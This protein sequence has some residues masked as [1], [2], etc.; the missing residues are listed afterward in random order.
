MITFVPPNCCA[1]TRK[2]F[3]KSLV[4]LSDPCPTNPLHSEFP[5]P[6]NL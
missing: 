3:S 4:Q 5:Y 6:L 1:K 2:N